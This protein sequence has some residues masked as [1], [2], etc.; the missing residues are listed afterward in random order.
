MLSRLVMLRNDGCTSLDSYLR[1]SSS[2][3]RKATT[4]KTTPA[5][6]AKRSQNF[7]GDNVRWPSSRKSGMM[8]AAFGEERNGVCGGVYGRSWQNAKVK[9]SQVKSSQVK[10]SQVKSL[11]I[12]LLVAPPVLAGTNH[13]TTFLPLYDYKNPVPWFLWIEE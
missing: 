3:T 5:E 7:F 2:Q 10:S 13:D 4:I 11:S 1:H 8:A 6:A 12:F 9:S